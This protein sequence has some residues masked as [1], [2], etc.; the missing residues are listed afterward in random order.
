MPTPVGPHISKF[1][2][3]WM[4]TQEARSWIRVR[5][6]PGAAEKSKWARVLLLS[7]PDRDEHQYLVVLAAPLQFIIEQQSQELQR[8][9]LL[10]HG[11]GN[12]HIQ[13]I[14]ACPRV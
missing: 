7:H 10:I 12:A 6:I 9:Q 2:W 3:R 4:K 11:L 8:G 14:A 13:G 1:S 5:L